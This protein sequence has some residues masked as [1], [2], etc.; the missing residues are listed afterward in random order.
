MSV[1]RRIGG[2]LVAAVLTLFALQVA[3]SL[4]FGSPSSGEITRAQASPDWTVASIAGGANTTVQGSQCLEPPEEPEP[5]E[6][7]GPWEESDIR[8][9][10]L[11]WPETCNWT[12]YAT[13]GPG[14]SQADCSSP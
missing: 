14:A 2:S 6:E 7:E 5:P 3:P 9:E 13:V 4:A 10:E 1:G 11:F 12:P 8:W